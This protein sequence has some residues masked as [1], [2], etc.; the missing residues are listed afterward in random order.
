VVF[1]DDLIDQAKAEILEK[2]A[3]PDLGATEKD[4]IAEQIAIGAIKY[5]ILHIDR[6]TNMAFDF[7]TSL[8]FDGDSGPYLQYTYARCQ[9]VLRKAGEVVELLPTLPTETDV[10]VAEQLLVRWLYRFP[11]VAEQAAYAFAP[12]MVCQFLFQTAQYFNSFYNSLSILSAEPEVKQR[13]LLLTAATAQ[14]L[15]NGLALLGISTPER[16]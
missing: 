14:V 7:A 15:H 11:M 12:N 9:S 3:N 4:S 1:I 13:R 5:S 2:I 8:S 16:M 6:N 10:P